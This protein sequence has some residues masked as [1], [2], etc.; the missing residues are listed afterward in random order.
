MSASSVPLVAESPSSMEM[1]LSQEQHSPHL[2]PSSHALAASSNLS[3]QPSCQSAAGGL[4]WVSELW[5]RA[6]CLPLMHIIVKLS[7]SKAFL[8]FFIDQIQYDKAMFK[9]TNQKKH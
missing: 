8:F 4:Q 7:A 6:K 9:K 5:E 1:R 2:S 3:L